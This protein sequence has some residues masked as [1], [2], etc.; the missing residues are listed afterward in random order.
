MNQQLFTL[1]N[2]VTNI[3]MVIFRNS[4]SKRETKSFTHKVIDK[5]KLLVNDIKKP[6][7]L[8]RSSKTWKEKKALTS[9]RSFLFF[10]I[11]LFL[12]SVI[13]DKASVF[14]SLKDKRNLKF[15]NE[16]W[17]KLMSF[18][19]KKIKLFE[20]NV[21]FFPTTFCFYPFCPFF[22]KKEIRLRR[23]R[24]GCQKTDHCGNLLNFST[25]Q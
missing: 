18:H 9:S 19:I 6:P 4:F 3:L 24:K 15:L 20:W 2:Y 10:V 21:L 11:Y 12:S 8:Y 23:N 14:S 1:L 13:S 7:P 5:K 16:K 17:N 25:A 22:Q